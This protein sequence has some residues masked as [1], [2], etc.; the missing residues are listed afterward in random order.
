M[1]RNHV[2]TSVQR[3]MQHWTPR[4]Q[5]AAPAAAPTVPFRFWQYPNAV[6][7]NA[8]S[9]VANILKEKAA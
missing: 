5:E 1:R 3:Q 8:Q 9:V 7:I 2:T 4:Y 6:S